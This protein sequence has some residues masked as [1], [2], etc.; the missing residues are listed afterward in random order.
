MF[1]EYVS[2]VTRRD[3]QLDGVSGTIRV[4]MVGVGW[5]TREEA[6]PAVADSTYCET[7]VVV[8]SLKEKATAVAAETETIEYG[9]TYPEFEAGEAT[10][11]YDAVYVC[12]PNGTH[13]EYVAAAAEHG[14]AV[15]CEKPMEATVERARDL[16]SVC[17][18]H[19]VPLMIAYRMQT[20]PLVRRAKELI[21]A[22]VIGD[23]VQVHSDD[24]ATLLDIFPDRDQWRLDPELAGGCA[25]IDLGIYP[26]NTIRFLLESDPV[27]VTGTTQSIHEPFEEVDESVWFELQFEDS[28]GAV[29]TASHGA[30]G[31]S[32]LRIVGRD[33]L[34]ELENIYHPWEDRSLAVDVDG[35][36]T[37]FSPESVDQMTEEF[38]YF[39]HCLLT[40]SDPHPDG[41]HGLTDMIILDRI[42]EAADAGERLK[43]PIA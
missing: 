38:D 29:C 4:A 1:E 30:Y 18:E 15:L 11:A 28:A 17:S 3:W 32:N 43:V 26:V 20:E 22:G 41:D 27:A 40:D 25:L 5:W 7:T 14:K 42:Y 37:R 12:T 35:D 21:A 33:G 2:D 13:L 6:I 23:V 24:S 36:R 39:A 10:D 31:T 9:L 34:I 16:V 19:G 8:S